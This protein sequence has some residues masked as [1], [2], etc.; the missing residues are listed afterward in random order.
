MKYLCSGHAP[1]SA[2]F[3]I[4]MLPE[5]RW[6]AEFLKHEIPDYLVKG[7][8]SFPLDYQIKNF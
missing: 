8:A 2:I 3:N 4:G 5:A 7:L 1:S 6:Y